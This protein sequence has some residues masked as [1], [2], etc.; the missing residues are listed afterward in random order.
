MSKRSFSV[1]GMFMVCVSNLSLAQTTE[2]SDPTEA[3]K[4]G[5]TYSFSVSW[6]HNLSDAPN[7][8]NFKKFVKPVKVPEGST[9]VAYL[10]VAKPKCKTNSPAVG[11]KTS[12]GI[13]FL[14]APPECTYVKVKD[15]N[16]NDMTQSKCVGF[17]FRVYESPEGKEVVMPY[18]TAFEV[19]TNEAPIVFEQNSV[20]GIKVFEQKGVWIRVQMQNIPPYN[21]KVAWIK[22]SPQIGQIQ[23]MNAAS[24]HPVP[25][26]APEVKI[27]ESALKFQAYESPE[28]KEVI[29][30]F[31]E[32]AQPDGTKM[33]ESLLS[34]K[35]DSR[36]PLKSLDTQ[37]KRLLIFER[38]GAWIQLEAIYGMTLFPIERVW[39]KATPELGE[40]KTFDTPQKPVGR[41]APALE[42]GGFNYLAAVRDLKTVNKR[43]WAKVEIRNIDSDGCSIDEVSPPLASGWI[44]VMTGTKSNLT[45][46]Y[47]D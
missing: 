43:A 36:D 13:H 40:I 1:L 11:E 20:G 18:Q 14:P 9:P 23:P 5:N 27:C 47:C 32:K 35:T 25:E 26:A 44:P 46:V 34:D 28:G 39:F 16:G 7:S 24:V 6:D 30:G 33:E 45:N 4:I 41:R 15:S 38:R 10:V 31:N 29:N 2:S 19:A 17:R 22:M 12:L 21:G 3:L 8:E 37:E 42:N